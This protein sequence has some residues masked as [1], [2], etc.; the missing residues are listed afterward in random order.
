MKILFVCHA[1]VGRSQ[2]AQ[3]YF[4]KLSRHFSDNV[5]IAVNELIA[6]HNGL[7]RGDENENYTGVVSAGY[8]A[9]THTVG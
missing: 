3:V 9:S 1:N 8:G 5:G 7:N 4:D 6:K 2:V